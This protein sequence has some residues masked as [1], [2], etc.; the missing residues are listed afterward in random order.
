MTR[1]SA[2]RLLVFASL[3]VPGAMLLLVLGVFLPRFYAAHA[4]LSLLAVG[5]T[6]TLVRLID[7][8]FDPLIGFA[9]D[10][11]RTPI[12][13]YRPW[14][15]AAAPVV[16]LAIWRLFMPPQG[17][18]AG[19]L[20]MW[21]VVLSAGGSMLA[22]GLAAW[23]ASLAASY[24]DRSRVYGWMQA[25]G[26]AAVILLLLLPALTR[27]DIQPAAAS[28]IAKIGWLLI[29]SIP[30]LFLIGI[31][32]TPDRTS[33]TSTYAAFS[34]NDFVIAIRRPDMMR[35]VLSD[36][37]LTLGPG[38][39]APIY[40]FFFHDA[41]LFS[42]PATTTLLIFY[43][44]AGLFGA[45]AWAWIAQRIGKHRT[46]QIACVAYAITQTILMILPAAIY[47]PT[48]IGM[49]AVG[50]CV[51]AFPLAVRA[52]VADISDVVRLEQDRDLTSVLYAMV[53]TTSKIGSSIT[54]GIS[55]T[56]LAFVGYQASEAVQNTPQAIF[57]LEMVYLFPPIVLVFFGGA[58]FFGYTLDARRHGEVREALE[59]REYAAAEESLVGLAP[60]PGKAA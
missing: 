41:K 11:T 47:L 40:I 29:I 9:M 19:Y 37:F 35:I 58:M 3:G 33:T 13:R 43:I 2:V 12:G 34:L 32:A 44:G 22:L 14:L 8:S 26:V 45:P 59:A 53:T 23:A 56:I 18:G 25:V 52:M 54:S 42:I 20:V 48:A 39:T 24:H 57:G 6:F 27:G 7:I 60:V 55:F 15:L 51:S 16:M 4:H 46:V 30:V 17:I 10:R 50:F 31:P 49:F 5:G 28:G 36:L 38:M 21:L 1:L